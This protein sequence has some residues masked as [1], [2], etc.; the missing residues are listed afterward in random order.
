MIIFVWDGDWE[1]SAEDSCPQYPFV[2]EYNP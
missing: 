1:D 2:F